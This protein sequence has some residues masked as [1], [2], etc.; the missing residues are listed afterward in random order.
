[1]LKEEFGIWEFNNAMLASAE[2]SRI[3]R[4]DRLDKFDRFD[5]FVKFG[6]LVKLDKLD[7]FNPVFKKSGSLKFSSF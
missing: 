1:M 5:K 6:R 2:F 3:G 7:R 4:F